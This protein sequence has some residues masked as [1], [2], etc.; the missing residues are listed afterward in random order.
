MMRQNKFNQSVISSQNSQQS[1][2]LTQKQRELE[3]PMTWRGPAPVNLN[4]GLRIKNEPQSHSKDRV[5]NATF[6]TKALEKVTNRL[7]SVEQKS[8]VERE[9]VPVRLIQLNQASND[10]ALAQS[11]EKTPVMI[12]N[13]VRKYGNQESQ[14]IKK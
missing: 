1:S 6:Q 2:V 11:G 14:N 8:V 12:P 9:K 10:N 4:H 13:T 7:T 5:L 3:Q